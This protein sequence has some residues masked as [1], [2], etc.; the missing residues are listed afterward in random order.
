MISVRG[1]L[2]PN[3][4]GH[5]GVTIIA[6]RNTSTRSMLCSIGATNR[7][8]LTSKFRAPKGGRTCFGYDEQADEWT[9]QSGFDGDELRARPCIEMVTVDAITKTAGRTTGRILRVLSF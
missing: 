4:D 1:E 8:P 6:K 7:Q 3:C 2:L 5:R 9:L